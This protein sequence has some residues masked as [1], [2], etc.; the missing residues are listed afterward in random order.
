MKREVCR[1]MMVV[2][3]QCSSSSACLDQS[4]VA[5]GWLGTSRARSQVGVRRRSFKA[6]GREL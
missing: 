6:M 2:G 4:L 1:W 5:Q 3:L